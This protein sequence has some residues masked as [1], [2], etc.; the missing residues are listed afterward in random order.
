VSLQEE[1]KLI[2]GLITSLIFGI[3]LADTENTDC[4]TPIYNCSWFGITKLVRRILGHGEEPSV[5]PFATDYNGQLGAIVL[6]RNTFESVQE[7]GV[8]H[9]VKK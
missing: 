9:I 1:I 7:F 4:D 6:Y 5:M 2:N 3:C 8:Y